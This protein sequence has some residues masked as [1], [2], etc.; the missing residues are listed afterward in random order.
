MTRC[1]CGILKSYQQCC[2]AIILGNKLAI[3]PEQLMRS[4]YTAYTQLNIDYIFATMAGPA[5]EQA[6]RSHSLAWAEQCQ[7]LGLQVLKSYK[8][9]HNEGFV[10]F[11]ASFCLHGQTKKMHEL[12]RFLLIKDQWFYVS[13]QHDPTS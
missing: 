6:D 9:S 10:E 11:I 3:T 13:G 2:G 4:R 7:W 12:S 5:L 1:P 8:I